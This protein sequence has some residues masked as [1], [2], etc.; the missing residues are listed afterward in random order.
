MYGNNG[1]SEYTVKFWAKQF[2]W[3]RDSIED[4]PRA[5]RP[6]EA[7][8]SDIC[9]K[10]EGL[11]A[12][13]RR[14][15][16]SSL[17]VQCGVSEGTVFDI[18]HNRLGMSKVSAR[19]VPKN[20]SALQKR[21]RADL[22]KNNLENQENPEDFFAK[23]VTGDETWVHHWD[24]ETKQESMQ[25]KHKGS[26]PPK[27]FRTQSSAGKAMATIFWDCEGILLTEYMAKHTTI[28]AQSYA[29]TL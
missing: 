24:P 11:V 18:L 15:K 19:W 17:A 23:L 6:V 22:N 9:E 20:L 2:K 4:D 1:P 29:N 21:T 7:T 27:K 10:I 12:N 13:D 25:W 26:P 14:I 28:N 3:G 5:G 16:I 8:S